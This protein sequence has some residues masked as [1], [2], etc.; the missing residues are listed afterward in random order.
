MQ[1]LAPT[2]FFRFMLIGYAIVISILVLS[3]AG[4]LTAQ[5][6]TKQSEKELKLYFPAEQDKWERVD[7]ADVGWDKAKLDMALNFAS[8]NNS[9]GV[10]VLYRG[11]ILAEEYWEPKKSLRYQSMVYG[12][13]VKGHA[14]EDVASVQKSVAAILLGVA[15]DK[16]LVKLDD[17]VEKHLGQGWSN[18]SRESESKITLRHLITMTTGLTDRLEFSAPAGTKWKYN[19]NAYSRIVNV[20]ESASKLDRN[21]LTRQWFGPIGMKDSRWTV[22]RFARDDPKTNRHGFVTSARDL[23]RFGLLILANGKWN[24]KTVVKDTDYLRAMTQPS[25]KL[26][27]SYG[28]LW[29]L[30]GQSQILRAGRGLRSGSLLPDAPKDLVAGLGALGRKVYVVPSLHLVVTRLGDAPGAKFDEQFWK[31]LMAAAPK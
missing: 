7:P 28:Y 4:P 21:E 10:V 6:K 5:E 15:L 14:L 27:P 23:G 8:E 29:W 31:R 3:T 18:A 19:T 25:Q 9:S 24:G 22:R 26:N 2:L 1:S 12:E 13:D 20:M 30:N 11:R 17:Q 16:N